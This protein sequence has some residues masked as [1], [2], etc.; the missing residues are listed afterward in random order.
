MF[1]KNLGEIKAVGFD[2]DGTL[3]SDFQLH[4]RMAFH[5]FRYSQFFLKY[6]M[7]RSTMHSDERF[8]N[9]F[10][11]QARRMAQK[12]HCTIDDAKE[13]LERIVYRGLEKFFK[14]IPP[15]PFVVETFEAFHNAGLRLALLSDFPPEQKGELWSLPK[16][17]DVMIGTESL[18]ALKP[19]AYPFF[20]LAER[21]N[22]APNEILFVG[23]SLKY[24]VAGAKKTLM[25]TA[26][27][28]PKWK[29]PFLKN[30]ADIVFSNYRT[31][32]KI[33][34]Q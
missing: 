3:Y 15:R 17:C 13:R 28:A 4:V 14:N 23:N 34:L 22:I 26:L 21:L 12:I 9:F 31:L 2:I 33:V 20:V 10:D 7:V 29:V 24:D 27:V 18:G 5:F 11:E 16:F 32:Q 1:I 6:G 8:E 25:K 30:K 19:S